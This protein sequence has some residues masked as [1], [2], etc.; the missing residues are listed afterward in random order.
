[1]TTAEHPLPAQP[2]VKAARKAEGF[3]TPKEDKKPQCARFLPKRVLPIVF[4]PGIMGSNLK[5]SP[6]RQKMLRKKVNIAWRPDSLGATN[7]VGA[8]TLK[9]YERQLMLDPAHTSVD[10]YDSAGPSDVCG[11]GRNENVKLQRLS[12]PPLLVDDPFTAKDGRTAVQKARGRGWGEV[13][14]NSYGGLLQLLESRLNNTFSAGKLRPEWLEVV[15][16]DPVRWQATPDLPQKALQEDEVKAIADGCWFPVYAFGYNWL[17][18]NAISACH[19]AKRIDKLIA[20]LCKAGYECNQVVVI[21]H[22]MGGLVARA[23]IHPAYGNALGNILGM[24]HGVMPAMGAPAAYKRMRAGFEDPGLSQNP[25]GSI[26]AKVAGN[27][28]DEVTA[29]LANS[30]GG[31]ELLPNE[32]YGNEWLQINYRGAKLAA[33]PRNGDPYKEIYKTKGKWFSLLREDWINPSA[34]PPDRGGGSF[35]RTCDYLDKV[36]SFHRRIADTFHPNSFAHYGTDSSRPTFSEVVWEISKHCADPA[37]WQDWPIISDTRQGTLEI[38]RWE[39]DQ[40]NKQFAPR[41]GTARPNS[42]YAVLQGPNSPGDQTVP[43]R[44]SDQ[45]LHSRKMRGVFRQSGYE[46]QSSYR[47]SRVIAATL[48]SIVRIA[49]QA[50]WLCQVEK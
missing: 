47:D 50:K 12:V 20:G 6:Q 28:G 35:E 13:Y 48:Y 25:V 40:P 29:V 5:L 19:I 34:L 37:G 49:Q 23:L 2:H 14:F 11:D 42:I 30:H 33:W 10:G 4:L 8:S 39:P 36:Q 32:A 9:P 17:E 31:L 15:G 44:S 27:C 46:H 21:T 3:A 41:I 7:T 45:Q 18:S 43:S 16:V 1:M 38:A 26:G 24:V 22:S